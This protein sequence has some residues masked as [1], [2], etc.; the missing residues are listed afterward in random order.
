MPLAGA[1][2]ASEDDAWAGSG[3]HRSMSYHDFAGAIHQTDPMSG[4]DLD[5]LGGGGGNGDLFNLK[6]AR[7]NLFPNHVFG[8]GGQAPT[9]DFDFNE[10]PPSS[11]PALP[12]EAF[13]T[14]EEEVFQSDAD[15]H[16]GDQTAQPISGLAGG[17]S[18]QSALAAL[19]QAYGGVPDAAAVSGADSGSTAE[20]SQM[21]LGHGNGKIELDRSTVNQLLAMLTQQQAGAG[22]GAV[23]AAD[24]F[25][26]VPA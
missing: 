23:A 4:F 21:L 3:L 9:S 13:P 12:S 5:P 11:P 7:K 26:A 16:P 2:P 1:T 22:A 19:L 15:D 8:N 6:G 25:G 14:P 10:L 18:T 17:A 24:I 20:L